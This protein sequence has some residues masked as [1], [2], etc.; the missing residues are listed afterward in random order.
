MN[1]NDFINLAK[2]RAQDLAEYNCLIFRLV[3]N[4]GEIILGYP[5]DKRT[6]RICVEIVNGKVKNA[7]I[8]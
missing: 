4:D 6:D 7:S 2:H 8:Q 3:S 1:A 5:E